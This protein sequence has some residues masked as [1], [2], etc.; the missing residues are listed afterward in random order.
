MVIGTADRTELSEILFR[1]NMMKGDTWE[2][3]IGK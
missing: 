1:I 3:L 2:Q